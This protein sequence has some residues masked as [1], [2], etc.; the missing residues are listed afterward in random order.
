LTFALP[1]FLMMALLPHD[2]LAL[3]GKNFESGAA[4]LVILAIG[5]IVNAATA[6]ANSV[7]LLFGH[8]RLVMLNSFISGILQ[9]TMNVILIPRYGIAGAA[10]AASVSLILLDI[11]RVIEVHTLLGVQPYEWNIWKPLA[12]GVGTFLIVWLFRDWLQV[13]NLLLL[14]SVT[15]VSYFAGLA[16]LGL[17]GDDR[18]A[19]RATAQR[20]RRLAGPA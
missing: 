4:C 5:Q 19:L 10:V 9:I 11:V 18:T 17:D 8:S 3:F 16:A 13:R 20:V 15:A 12:A 2:I 7:L 1:I 14:M 6:S